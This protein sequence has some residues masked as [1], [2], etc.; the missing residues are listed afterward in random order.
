MSV[1]NRR[2]ALRCSWRTRSRSTPSSVPS[3]ARVAGS[4]SSSPYLRTRTRRSRSVIPSIASL[5][6]AFSISRITAFCISDAP[7]FSTNSPSSEAPSSPKTGW[8]RLVASW[9]N[10]MAARASRVVHP[11]LAATSSSVGSRPSWLRVRC[12]RVLSCEPSPRRAPAAVRRVTCSRSPPDSLPHPPDSVGRKAVAHF[13]V[14]PLD[15]GHQTDVAL[16]DE[17]LEGQPHLGVALGHADHK[18]QVLLDEPPAGILV[19]GFGLMSESQL[20][21]FRQ[22]PA[23]TDALE[24]RGQKL[25]RLPFMAPECARG[26]R[27]VCH[28]AALRRGSRLVRAMY[29]HV[30]H[31]KQLSSG[32]NLRGRRKPQSLSGR[33]GPPCGSVSLPLR[34]SAPARWTG[35]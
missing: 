3:S 24:I 4:R 33:R 23:A 34:S 14:E 5:S 9:S 20:F 28:F 16:L 26:A 35:R 8:S 10:P 11:S 7:S 19:S 15:G 22:E 27:E 17:V 31:L 30:L 12:A 21:F 29:A 1:L 2:S 13:G 6:R 25:R 18:P 32:R